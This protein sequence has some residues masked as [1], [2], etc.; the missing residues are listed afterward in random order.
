MARKRRNVLLI[1]AGLGILAAAWAM[2]SR[3]A[4]AAGRP[5]LIRPTKPGPP[6]GAIDIDP[7][8]PEGH[9]EVFANYKQFVD[10]C[11]ERGAGLDQEDLDLAVRTLK[12][13]AMDE[14][15]PNHAWP[16]DA[17]AHQWQHNVWNDLDFLAYVQGK[18]QT[19]DIPGP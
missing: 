15:F 13:C 6:K 18:F 10:G 17:T 9:Q 11:F 4:A 7:S 3:K 1:G 2:R 5:G 19:P 16:P 8:A 12:L 14:M